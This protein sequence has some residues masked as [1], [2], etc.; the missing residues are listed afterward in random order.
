MGMGLDLPT[1]NIYD[2]IATIFV[3][4][5][6]D[7]K[8][9]RKNV[10]CI[11]RNRVVR[12]INKNGDTLNSDGTLT[13]K[14]AFVTD[15]SQ[16]TGTKVFKILG[17]IDLG[18][19]SIT[20]PENSTLDFQGGKITNGTVVLW[21]TKVLPMGCNISD[22][23]TATIQNQYAEGQVLYDPDLKKM[24]LWNGTSWVNLDGTALE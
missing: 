22:Y 20:I 14:V 9:E 19:T 15:K 3:N 11:D 5:R 23:I 13:S 4:V 16:I 12:F 8:S 2:E 17:D 1:S 7:S 18:G 21:K 6:N 10:I 24:K